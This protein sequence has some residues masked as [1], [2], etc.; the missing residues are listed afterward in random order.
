MQN[1]GSR[2]RDSEETGEVREFYTVS[3][4]ADLLQLTEMT[5]Y[6]MV[7]RAEL[8]CYSIGRVKRFRH[9]DIEEFLNRCRVPAIKPRERANPKAD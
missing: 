1:A 3:Q 7:N 9:R 6:R 5:I 2:R 4:L 8:P